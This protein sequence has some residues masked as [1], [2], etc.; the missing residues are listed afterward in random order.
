MLLKD[1]RIEDKIKDIIESQGLELLDFN[2]FTTCGRH[3]VRCIV[4]YPEGGITMDDCAKVNRRIFSYLEESNSLG[5]DFSVEIN[6]PGLDRPLKKYQ[7][8]LRV[9]GKNISLWLSEPVCGKEYL[10]GEVKEVEEGS[11]SLLYKGESVK[12]DF[13]KI[14]TGKERIEIK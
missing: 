9:K 3:I 12:I 7:D 8:F 1:K 4:D 11:L 2:I 10:E 14:K 5:D 13:N 6:S